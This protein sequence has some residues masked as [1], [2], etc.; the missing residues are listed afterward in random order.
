MT[1]KICSTE[2]SFL[3]KTNVLNTYNVSYFKCS[4]CG[5]IQ[6]EKPYWLEEAYK[7]PINIS[8]TGIVLRNQRLSRIVTSLIVLL[9][10]RKEKILDYAGGFG[11]FTRMMRDIGFDFY[12]S[13]P[14]TKNEMARGFE[15][16]PGRKYHLTTTFESFEHFENPRKELETILQFSENIILSTELVPSPVPA[17]A[18]WWYYGTE[19]GQHIALYTKK[20]FEELARQFGLHYYNLDNVHILTKKP[21]SVFQRTVLKLPYVKY[22]LYLTSFFITPFL[23]SKTFD[24]MNT[25]K[26]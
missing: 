23:H 13:D 17:A 12:W 25:Y 11:L 10:N 24:D 20:A 26:H 3:F 21:V 18:D 8:D 2:S 14:Y 9:F 16:E 4:A 15:V 22:L 6:T 5:F 7:N 1:C 19:H